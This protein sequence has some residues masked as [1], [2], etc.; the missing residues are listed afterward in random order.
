MFDWPLQNLGR[1][2]SYRENSLFTKRVQSLLFVKRY[3]LFHPWPM[4]AT[5]KPPENCTRTCQRSIYPGNPIR[6]TCLIFRTARGGVLRMSLLGSS[7]IFFA[8]ASARSRSFSS[9]T[10]RE[11]QT[12]L[13]M[14]PMA[15]HQDQTKSGSTI[16]PTC[17]YSSI[18]SVLS[19]MRVGGLRSA[20]AAT[21]V[22]GRNTKQWTIISKFEIKFKHFAP[23]QDSSLSFVHYGII[24]HNILI[25]LSFSGIITVLPS[26]ERTWKTKGSKNGAYVCHRRPSGSRPAND[27]GHEQARRNSQ[28][29]C[30]FDQCTRTTEHFGQIRRGSDRRKRSRIGTCQTLWILE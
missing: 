23:K 6:W 5:M 17:S 13:F 10:Q 15:R 20:M 7:V 29:D 4:T 22:C 28:S 16:S 21:S 9:C 3:C 12:V 14:S 26:F 11:R 24:N 27:T 2:C 18:S 30:H 19:S 8:S 1:E 25:I